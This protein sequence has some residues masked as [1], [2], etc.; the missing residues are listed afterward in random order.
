MNKYYCHFIESTRDIV[1]T[2]STWDDTKD[3]IVEYG[4]NG[5]ILNSQGKSKLFVD[6]GPAKR[7][8]YIH[9]VTGIHLM[10]KYFIFN[11]IFIGLFD[12]LTTRFE[13]CISLWK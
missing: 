5:L 13:V 9:T 1:V 6:G 7:S 12:G 2:W 8:Q 4:I 10:Y 3:S 11:K